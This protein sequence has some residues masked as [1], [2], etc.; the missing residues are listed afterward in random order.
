MSREMRNVNWE[1]ATG[2][3]KRE[4]GCSVI[5][6]SSLQPPASSPT[7]RNARSFSHG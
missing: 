4:A 2:N 7:T 3:V 1:Q 6:T 5:L